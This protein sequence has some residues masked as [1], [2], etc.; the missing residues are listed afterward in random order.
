VPRG[1]L[2]TIVKVLRL[3]GVGAIICFVTD[4]L[5][6]FNKYHGG[7]D[8]AILSNNGD[9]FRELFH[10]I[11]LKSINFT[12]RWMPSHL[13]VTDELPPGVTR[14]DVIGNDFA[15]KEA[16]K[17][18]I[19]HGV[20]LNASVNVLYYRNLARRIQQ[21]IV[22]IIQS[23]DKRKREVKEVKVLI[24]KPDPQALFPFSSHAAFVCGNNIKCAR[25]FAN[26]D[27]HNPGVRQ[28][29][30]RDCPN[31]NQD[32]DR[33]KPLAHEY[34]HFGSKPLHISHR[35][36]IFKGLVY[37]RRCGCKTTSHTGLKGLAGQCMAPS[38]FGIRTL[39]ALSEGKLPPKVMSWPADALHP[40]LVL[41]AKAEPLS[42]F[43][44]KLLSDM[45]HLSSSEAK[46]IANC[47]LRVAD[48][49]VQHHHGQEHA[50][51]SHEAPRRF[52]LGPRPIYRRLRFSP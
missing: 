18:A 48:Y 24:P 42:T 17:A 14:L 33:P 15:D 26:M 8:S 43:E 6:N 11:R 47:M 30:L 5:G 51:S 40:A 12:L 29:L 16:G 7:Y 41:S 2:F 39:K 4:N 32:S 25:C 27:K 21:R 10:I 44:K 50:S 20:D 13:K 22:A 1:E 38:N 34:C 37:C 46:I 49:S 45:P 28:W 9:L 23:L 36:N 35:L 3:A 19:K 52:V 31:I